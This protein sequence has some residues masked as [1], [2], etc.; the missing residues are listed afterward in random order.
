MSALASIPIELHSVGCKH[1]FILFQ[2]LDKRSH[3]PRIK[4]HVIVYEKQE[5]AGGTRGAPV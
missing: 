5:I 1:L 2:R 3:K 4:A